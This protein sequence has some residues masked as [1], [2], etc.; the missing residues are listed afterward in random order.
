MTFY[1][2]LYRAIEAADRRALS[3]LKSRAFPARRLKLPPI[4]I[5]SLPKTGSVYIQR[6]LRR[7]LQIQRGDVRFGGIVDV[8]FDWDSL[9]KMAE[10]KWRKEIR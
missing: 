10:S 6:A 3:A 8:T 7:T 4:F 2:R 5:V 9:V 1:K